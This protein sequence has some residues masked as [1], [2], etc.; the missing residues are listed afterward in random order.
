[1]ILA[2]D[3]DEF[4]LSE[5]GDKITS[6]EYMFPTNKKQPEFHNGAILILSEKPNMSCPLNPNQKKEHFTMA[7][8][9]PPPSKPPLKNRDTPRVVQKKLPHTIPPPMA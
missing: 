6:A 8:K 2:L 5:H 1:M 9:A 3:T 4:Y 7:G